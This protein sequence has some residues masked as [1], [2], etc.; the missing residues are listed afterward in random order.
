MDKAQEKIQ[1]AGVKTDT[2]FKRALNL[3]LEMTAKGDIQLDR[4]SEN[5]LQRKVGVSRTTI[6]KV[7]HELYERQIII[8][9]G[10]TRHLG[11]TVTESDYFPGTETTPK[12]QYVERQFMEWMLRGNAQPGELINELELARLFGAS[13][14]A[15]REFLNRFSR[16]GLVEKKPN[17]GWLFS[18]FTEQFAL[19]LFEIRV[20]FELRS[21]RKFAELPDDSSLWEELIRLQ[22]AH[23]QLLEHIADRY[24]DFSGLDSE[25]HQ[26][27]NAAA[28]NRFINEF[29]GLIS[30][31][32]HFHYQWNKKDE[33]QRNEAAIVEHLAYI[34]ALF[35]RSAKR[36]ERACLQHMASAKTT[37]LQ[38]LAV[39]A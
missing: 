16:F 25:F 3:I 9:K 38:S 2:V 13:T 7:L 12:H 26:L 21:A 36:I 6:R 19:E 24:Q 14:N 5:E 28:P 33:R 17:S 39:E 31:I 11:R 27:V 37:L 29:Y 35:S 1:E 34:D 18:G 20:M 23:E 32:F 30:F 8:D 4:A 15:I 22:A 10:K